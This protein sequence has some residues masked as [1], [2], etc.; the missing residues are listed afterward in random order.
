MTRQAVS[1]SPHLK[2][3]SRA[4]SRRP[5]D[6]ADCGTPVLVCPL[7]YL[8]APFARSRS[9]GTRA[10]VPTAT[11]PGAR[12]TPGPR[13]RTL[14]MSQGCHLRFRKE[15]ANA[16][17]DILSNF[18]KGFTVRS[19]MTQVIDALAAARARAH[20]IISSSP[21]NGA[22]AH[23]PCSEKPLATSE[24]ANGGDDRVSDCR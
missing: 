10:A 24:G 9:T 23:V 7:Q 12:R 19:L 15:G 6:C 5:T 17:R 4:H 14:K 13:Q 18:C 11:L 2:P 1:A 16:L 3:C 22:F 8:D 20:L 21:R